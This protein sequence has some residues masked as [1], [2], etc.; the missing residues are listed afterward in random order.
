MI[1]VIADDLSGAAELAGIAANAGMEAQVVTW[2]EATEMEHDH[3]EISMIAVDGDT[4]S[5]I[6]TA[7]ADRMREIGEWVRS[8]R[9]EWVFKKVDSVLRGHVFAE[10]EALREALG[11]SSVTLVSANP[12]KGRVIRKGRYF[13]ND[14]PLNQTTFAHDPEHPRWTADVRELLGKPCHWDVPDVTSREALQQVVEELDLEISLP[15]GAAD[16]FTSLLET[17]K[18]RRP[19]ASTKTHPTSTTR[20]FLCGSAASW[21]ARETQAR[22]RGVPVRVTGE[23]PPTGHEN[24]VLMGLGSKRIDDV[25]AQAL[26]HRLAGDA[27][28]WMN[29]RPKGGDVLAEGGATGAALARAFGWSRLM[30]IPGAPTGTAILQPALDPKWRMWLKPGSYPWPFEVD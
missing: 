13:V 1:V 29:A 6:K 7:A 21:A 16:F 18:S 30:V 12:S 27:Q 24:I 25:P 17:T 3:G 28:Q 20:L 26:A 23:E 8:L 10:G 14:V 9:V 5:L 2:P 4:R 11:R 19:L 15:V 22:S